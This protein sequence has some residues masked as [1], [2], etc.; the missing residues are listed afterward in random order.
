MLCLL[1]ILS[2]FG[3]GVKTIQQTVPVFYLK[4]VQRYR[5]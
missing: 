3:S 2:N 5:L 1:T 4:M